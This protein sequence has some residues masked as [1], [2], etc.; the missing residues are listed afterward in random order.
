MSYNKGRIV[1]MQRLF[2]GIAK[3]KF[4]D[5]GLKVKKI[6]VGIVVLLLVAAGIGFFY[7]TTIDWNQHK[8]KIAEQFYQLTGKTVSFEGSL[9]FKIFPSPYL[10]ATA[11]KV[12]NGAEASGKPL[13]EIKNVVAELALMPLLSGEFHVKKMILDGAIVN[14]DW[15][16]GGL[17]WQNDLSPDQRQM[18]E[19]KPMVLNSVSLRN[20]VVNFEAPSSGISVHLTNLNGEV[21]AQSIF[22]PFRIEGNYLKGATP[23]G[24]A[25]SI[26]K[27]SE[28]FATTLNAVVTHPQSD[29]YV[30]FDG[31]FQL[32]N[33]VLNGN[34]IVD[35]QKISDF[36]NANFEEAH[37]PAEYNIPMALGF[38]VALDPQKLNLSNI[39]I[40]YGNTQGAGMFEMPL[41][42]INEPEIKTVFNFTDLDLD[43][44]A[45]VIKKSIE[46][47]EEEGFIPSFPFELTADV[48]AIRASHQGQGMKELETLVT[49]ADETV[50]VDD[51]KVILPGNTAVSLAGS[52]YPDEGEL[53]FQADTTISANDLLKTLQ[54][55]RIEPKANAVSVYK[56]M[57]ATA[58]IAGNFERIQIS[59]YKITLDKSTLSGEAGIVFGDRK[60]F[61]LVVN[62]DT[63]NF[64]N[65][66]SS[67]PEEEKA[68]SWGE[69]MAYR[70]GRLGFLNDFDMVL[71]AKA[72]MVIYESM[73]F[74]RVDFKGNILNGE[75]EIEYAK[76]E[77]VAN[78]AIDVKGKIGGFGALPQMN[79]FQYDIKSRDTAS[80]INKLELRVPEL[81]YKKFNT[82]DMSGVINGDINNFETDMRVSLGQLTGAYKGNILRTDEETRY[83][84]YLEF[85]YPD[86]VALLENLKT[87]YEP[88]VKNL[89]LLNFKA[90]LDGSRS[91]MNF[92]ELEA[93]IGYTTVSGSG[94]YENVDERPNV[95]GSFDINKLELEKFLPRRKTASL[96]SEQPQGEVTF[97][98]K[99][100]W[101]REPIDYSPYIYF[102]FKGDFKIG[103]LSYKTYMFKD[104]QFGFDLVD[105]TATIRD[106][107]G[108]YNN[109]PLTASASLYMREAPTVTASVG[110]DNAKV[111]DFAFGGRVYNLRGGRFSTRFDFSSKADSEQ[112]F[113]E[114]LK[115]KGEFDAD[116]TEVNGVDL[117]AIYNDLLKRENTEGLL[118]QVKANIGRGTTLF[119]KITGRVIVDA[120]HFSLADAVM[121][122]SN[123]EVKVYGE[124]DLANW[125]MNTVFNIRYKEPKYLPEFSFSLKNAMNN[126]QVDVNASSL[127][128]LYQNREEQKEAAAAAEAAAEKNYWDELIGE[129]RKT[130]DDLVSSVRERLEKDV[131]L[132]MAEAFASDSV[133]Q[134]NLLKQKIANVL[135][136][137]VETMDNAPKEFSENDLIARLKQANEQALKEVE[138]LSKRKDDIYLAD[139]KK[140][141]SDIYGKAVELHN[142]IKQD[143]FNYNTQIDQYKE[144]LAAIITDYVL[145]DDAAFL[146]LRQKIETE[147]AD[148]ESFNDQMERIHSLNQENKSIE[149]NEKY[150]KEIQNIAEQLEEGRAFLTENIG[151]LTGYVSG[152]VKKAEDDY[153]KKLEEEENQRMLEENTGSISIKKTGQ[154]FTVTRDIEEIKNAKEE[155]SKEGVK[156]LDF[157]REKVSRPRG[158]SSR[159]ENVIKKGRN[160]R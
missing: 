61:M 106:F 115:G 73:P 120:G 96:I 121:Q 146:Q 112:S 103:E 62:A 83:R 100:F 102:D 72:D 82:F 113:A 149:E 90:N 68:K 118:E 18:M 131:D 41:G 77:Q 80:L 130:A 69:R 111:S 64:D 92:S 108:V 97:L 13:L 49:L 74:E 144:R 88:A 142:Q 152:V 125:D 154:T 39:V 79:G 143:V 86:V 56:K 6:V 22:G 129:Q 60:D 110:I 1:R 84:G 40:K 107:K 25:L 32:T 134:Y 145:D 30:R 128:K 26:G 20:A 55:L 15:D 70:F 17:S 91:N 34:V 157:S 87:K 114:N 16:E 37:V 127:F 2:E 158:E 53:Y 57:L 78:T 48:K 76:V 116:V 141:N 67:L 137:L 133:N 122:N 71:D 7:V 52:I 124:G 155:I 101:S 136:S 140:K 58:K 99:P 138:T 36:I 5:A 12:Y 59:P 11:A 35:S 65:Y 132:K 89:G 148:M 63:I 54:W 153:Q 28:S 19:D 29:S 150:S 139:L 47:Y 159:Q 21:L 46:K 38:D 3:Q 75:M 81:D 93:N 9:N 10:N 156:V 31:S 105:G 98:S 43:P 94:T 104:A 23:E 27:L 14:V 8:D 126:P 50:T 33:K 160:N 147:I 44:L 85:K 45:A 117:T 51:F 151:A 135:A 109:A 119:D 123:T 95:F 42:A 4:F 24:F 66:I